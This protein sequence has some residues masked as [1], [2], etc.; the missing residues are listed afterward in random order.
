MHWRVPIVSLKLGVAETDRN[1]SA[2]L[3]SLNGGVFTVSKKEGRLVIDPDISKL[4]IDQFGLRDRSKTDPIIDIFDQTDLNSEQTATIQQIFTSS[5]GSPAL[6][7]FC[8]VEHLPHKLSKGGRTYYLSCD[9]IENEGIVS[10]VLVTL[11]DATAQEGSKAAAENNKQVLNI[12]IAVCAMERSD[13][14]IFINLLESSIAEIYSDIGSDPRAVLRSLHNCKGLARLYGF[15]ELANQLHQL[16]GYHQVNPHRFLSSLKFLEKSIVQIKNVCRDRLHI[17][18]ESIGVY[19]EFERLWFWN[20]VLRT[21]VNIAGIPALSA[22]IVELD[23]LL[24]VTIESLIESLN[25][26]SKMPV[27]R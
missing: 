11:F 5:I 9:M 3:A 20:E 4:M 12:L 7:W 24:G 15:K 25:R 13:L 19:V 8:N 10:R 21:K 17:N 26:M 2:M 6:Q 18:F 23:Q 14:I 1:T 16:E 22:M 27:C